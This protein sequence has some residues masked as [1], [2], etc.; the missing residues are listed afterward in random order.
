MLLVVTV[1]GMGPVAFKGWMSF[2]LIG[3]MRRMAIRRVRGMAIGGVGMM[4]LCQ[5]S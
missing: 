4:P 3:R 5:L 2:V 1:R